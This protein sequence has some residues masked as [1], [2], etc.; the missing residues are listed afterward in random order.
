MVGRSRRDMAVD[1]TIFEKISPSR[2]LSFTI[3]NPTFPPPLRLLR[4]AILDSPLHPP[5]SPP[6]VAAM[7]VPKHR[8][9]DWIFSTESGHLQLLLNLPDISRLILIGDDPIDGSASVAGGED[10]DRERLEH[11]L[12]LLVMALSPKTHLENG[13]SDVPFL[14]YDDNLVRSVEIEKSVGEY[15]GEMLVEDV[16]LEVDGVRELR[17]RLRF[18]RMP[19]LVQTDIRIV[20]RTPNP[21]S[22]SMPLQGTEFRTDLT[23]LVHPYLAPM[24][25]SL[26]LIGSTIDELSSRPKA[27]CI[28]VGG[29]A[30]LSFL[31]LRLGFEVTGV[32][33]DPE[34]LRVARKYFGLEEDIASVHVEDGIEFLR[35]VSIDE[36]LKDVKFDA[37]MVDLDSSDPIHGV[38]A[39][40]VDFVSEDV[41][42]AARSVLHRS[43]ILV[44]NVIPQNRT[45]YDELKDK[46]R[47]VFAEL[48][49]IEVGNEENYVLIATVVPLSYS[50]TDSKDEF[51]RKRL[52]P[53]VPR[54]YVDTIERI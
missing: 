48:Y 49:E 53:A 7:L 9:T 19:N 4:V 24:V 46:F 51:S 17:R 45:F 8:E 18:K 37:V 27:L 29:G 47:R 25:A 40:P 26:S 44:I 36:A 6:R 16:E 23:V 13:I 30:L 50:V 15:V 32:E 33:I 28:G 21:G 43:G 42:L 3:P 54:K 35:R 1:V 31:N 14:S 39:P 11:S 52:T 22:N 2:F 12:R 10:R 20:P 5:E 34:V 41:L 38:T